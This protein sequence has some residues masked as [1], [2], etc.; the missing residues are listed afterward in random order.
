MLEKLC[1]GVCVCVCG[2]TQGRP[3][4]SVIHHYNGIWGTC[5]PG[6]RNMHHQGVI[7]TMVH[8]GDYVFCE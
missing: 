1:V 2:F 3:T 5:A 6:R 7:C 4:L 8:K